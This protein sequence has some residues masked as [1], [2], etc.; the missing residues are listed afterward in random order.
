MIIT[1]YWFVSFLGKKPILFF[2]VRLLGA[3][4]ILFIIALYGPL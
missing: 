3:I 1:L 2:I 4:I